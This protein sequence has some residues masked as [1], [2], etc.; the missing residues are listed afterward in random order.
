MSNRH[1]PQ[2]RW[3]KT[4]RLTEELRMHYFTY[5]SHIAPYDTPDRLQIMREN[6][7]D[8]RVKEQENV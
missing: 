8:I 1:E 4:R 2:K 7:V 5:L 3:G 6:V